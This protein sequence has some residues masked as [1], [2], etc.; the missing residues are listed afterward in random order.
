MRVTPLIIA[1][2]GFRFQDFVFD[3]ERGGCWCGLIA[4]VMV[5]L[6]VIG[7]AKRAER[8][9]N[10]GQLICPVESR[11]RKTTVPAHRNGVT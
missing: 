11:R 4:Q 6:A 8:F 9:C 5:L 2:L 1:A 7:C 3:C 10:Q